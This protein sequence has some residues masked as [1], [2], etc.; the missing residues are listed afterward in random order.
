M[1][2]VAATCGCFDIVHAGHIGLFQALRCIGDEVVVFLNADASVERLK[3]SG[4]P[5]MPFADRASILRSIRY[6]DSIIPFHEDIVVPSLQKFFDGRPEV[7]C[8]NFFWLKH[9]EYAR[10]DIPERECIEQRGGIVLFFGGPE[11][12]G[13]SEII[14]K[15][16]ACYKG[17]IVELGS[18]I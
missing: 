8:G 7:G 13:S 5:F 11:L 14:A 6:I 18:A 15:I 12:K 3:G 4:R 1:K 9:W 2:K 17:G 10:S 16:E